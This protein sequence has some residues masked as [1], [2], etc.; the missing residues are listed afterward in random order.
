[1]SVEFQSAPPHGGRL[2]GPEVTDAL[3]EFQSAPPHG[4]RPDLVLH[5]APVE[6]FQSAPPHGGR[7]PAAGLPPSSSTFQSAPPH[8]GRP[9]SR[10]S[11]ARPR[12]CF[13]PRPRM[14]GDD[15][16]AWG[17]VESLVS[18]RAPAWGATRA[19][20]VCRSWVRFQSAPPHGGRPDDPMPRVEGGTFQ[21]APPH[22]GRRRDRIQLLKNVKFAGFRESAIATRE[23]LGGWPVL[24]GFLAKNHRV[25]SVANLSGLLWSLGVRATSDEERPSGII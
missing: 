15:R 25:A 19:A 14:G 12:T 8:G 6:V 1:M 3:A 13:N 21:S 2:A 23:V 11:A 4:G 20:P 24:V 22:G 9:R 5:E 16:P 7:P 10:R 17:W 18:I